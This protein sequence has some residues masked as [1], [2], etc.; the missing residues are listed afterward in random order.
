MTRWTEQS[1]GSSGGLSLRMESGSVLYSVV[2]RPR[3]EREQS[4][5]E[6]VDVGV[7]DDRVDQMRPQLRGPVVAHVLDEQEAGPGH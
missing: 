5:A 7:L 3:R 4:P 2:D 6:S 1:P